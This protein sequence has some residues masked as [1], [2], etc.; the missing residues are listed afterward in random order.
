MG[1]VYKKS[2]VMSDFFRIFAI[3]KENMHSYKDI[4][5]NVKTQLV[6]LLPSG[7]KLVLFGSRARGDARDESDWD[8]LLL[9]D[10][11]RIES[12]DFKKYAYPLVN[13]GWNIGEYFSVKLYTLNDWL[14]RRGSAFYNNIEREGIALC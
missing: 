6:P 10:K 8:M 13:Y 11:P 3:G 2:L 12:P 4:I 14:K 5:D 9:L 7:A 1:S